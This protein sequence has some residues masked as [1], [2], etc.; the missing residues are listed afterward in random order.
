MANHNLSKIVLA[1]SG[2]LDTSVSARWLAEKYDA[3]VITVTVDVGQQENLNQ[4]AMRSKAI[5]VKSHYSIDAR[6]EF[7]TDYLS[8]AIKA[9][10]MYEGAY[11][12]ST[13]LSRP[14]I[15]SKLV[16]VARKE[17][18]SAVAHGCT[19]KG[20]DQ[21]RFEVTA[22]SLAPDIRVLAPVRDWNMSRDEEIKYAKDNGIKVSEKKSIYSVDQNMWGRSIEC[23]PLEDPN[24]EPPEEVYE[25]TT[26]PEKSPQKPE[27]ISLEFME[28]ELVGL[29]SDTLKVREIIERLNSIAGRHGVGRIDHIENRLVGIKS[30]EVYECPAAVCILAA[31][32]DLEKL[33]LTRHE[34]RFKKTIENRWASL[35]Y[36]GLWMEPLRRDLDVFIESTQ[37]RV[38]GT[39]RLKLYKGIATPIARTSPYSLYDFGMATY[40]ASSTFDQ[41]LAKG[42]IELWGLPTTIASKLILKDDEEEK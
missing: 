25:W 22:K 38:T 30:R 16:E 18:A 40:D 8:P 3:E 7:A 9:N 14:L 21:V 36:E 10:A 2:G 39:V 37:K 33:V 35:V 26:S 32:K 41:T 17:N 42:F 13:A 12:L 31:H 34:A 1:F 19:G 5:G 4:I 6:D 27:Y 28:G 29:N 15:C 20:N 11:P 23:G 24:V